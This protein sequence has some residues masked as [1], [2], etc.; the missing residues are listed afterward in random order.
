MQ[1]WLGNS[2][3]ATVCTEGELSFR[4]EEGIYWVPQ[5]LLWVNI[6]INNLDDGIENTIFK[7]EDDTTCNKDAETLEFKPNWIWERDLKK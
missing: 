7:P 3:Q 2:I 6:F 5:K 4:L 1:N